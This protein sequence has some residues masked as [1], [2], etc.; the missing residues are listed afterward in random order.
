[1][2]S[3]VGRLVVVLGLLA[4]AACEMGPEITPAKMVQTP[5]AERIRAAYPTFAR[6][7]GI[8]GK[9][10]M[11]CAYTLDG[12]VERCRK[13]GVAPEGLNFDKG[14]SGL[15]ADYIVE[16]QTIDGRAAP[17]EI[18]FVIHFAPPSAPPAWQGEPITDTEMRA[19]RRLVTAQLGMVDRFGVRG[20]AHRTVAIDRYPVVAEMLDRAFTA[21]GE[22]RND[23]MARALVQ[24]MTPEARRA[25]RRGGFGGASLYEMEAV[26][27]ELFAVNARIA[28]RIRD[29]YCAAYPCAVTRPGA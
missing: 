14:I 13:R 18:D 27:P 8:E 9:V 20:N 26:S 28:K 21:E 15:L 12:L 25:F 6:I 1:M 24:A 5:D 19:A 23:A 17:G 11:R 4:V 22:A 10:W 3:F 2:R 16:P 7:A 29:E